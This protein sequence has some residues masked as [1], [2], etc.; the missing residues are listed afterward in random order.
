[1]KK[2]Y[3]VTPLSIKAEIALN[4]DEAKDEELLQLSFDEIVANQLWK[5]NIFDIMNQLSPNALID[6]YESAQITDLAEMSNIIVFMES[7]LATHPTTLQGTISDL[8]VLF[9]KAVAV[10]T[11]VYFFF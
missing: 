1:M 6:D 8:I 5:A 4:T 7:N 2:W 3:I 10:K 9:K 11:G